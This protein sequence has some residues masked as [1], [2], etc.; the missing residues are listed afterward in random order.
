MATDD[1]DKLDPKVKDF[2][3]A[4]TRAELERWFGLPSFA[5]VADKPEPPKP[6]DPDV[7][8]VREQRQKAME[9]VD[10]VFLEAIRVRFEG[11]GESLILFQA[12]LSLRVDP[13]L[14]L[15]DYA[16]AERQASIAEPREVEISEELRDDLKDC[17]PQA[18]LRDLHR[19]EIDFDK[20][21]EIVDMSAEQKLD[22]VAEVKAAMTTNWKLPPL[23]QLPFR[24]ACTLVAEVVALRRTPWPA[25][26][27]SQKLPN[28]RVTE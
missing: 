1:E 7:I 18:I 22:I 23:E 5:E 9:S 21:F 13:D 16:M 12:K 3:D 24:E 14:A 19:P 25:L 27:L 11:K 8:R 20:T 2:I 6:E 10:P 26:V 15:F 28:R 17:T 4:A